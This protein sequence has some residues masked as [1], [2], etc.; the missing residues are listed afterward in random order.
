MRYLETQLVLLNPVAPHF[1]QYC[2]NHYV[3]PVL[4][5]SSNFGKECKQNLCDQKWP[6]ASAAVDQVA[7]DRLSYLKDTK[8]ALR[9]GFEQAKSGGKKK[10]KGGKQG[11]KGEA[12]KAE[13]APKPIDH[14]VVFIANE[15]PEFQQK[16]LKILQEFEFDE[17]NKI[18]GD[19]VSAIRAAFDKKEGGLAM[20]FVAF[21]LNIAEVSGKEAALRLESTFDEKECI[22]QNKAFLFENMAGITD[23]KVVLNNSLAAKQYDGAQG[24]RDA[25]A[26]SK[27][28]VYFHSADQVFLTEE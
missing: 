15:Y 11:K 26:P 27:P 3:Y 1:A 10:A 19:Y 14:C 18:Q 4:S 7:I 25:A 22:E 17:N 20:K 2:W 23:I 13:D 6:V 24:P 8:S 21:Q 16:C 9:V 28:A 12:A 5:A